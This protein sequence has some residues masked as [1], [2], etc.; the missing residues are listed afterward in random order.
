MHILRV[1]LDEALSSPF[2]GIVLTLVCY[3]IGKWVGGRYRSV[4]ANPFLIALVSIIVFLQVT[5]IPLES[6]TN[7]ADVFGLMLV[8]ATAF[9]GTTIYR[10]RLF[11][12]ANFFPIVLGCFTGACTSIASVYFLCRLFGVGEPLSTSLMP[13]SVTTPIAL[14]L[15]RLS[16]GIVP[17]TVATVALTGIAGVVCGP[18]LTRIF[19]IDDPIVAG[20]SYGT[21]SHV[22]G[23]TKALEL[24][25]VEGAASGISLCVTGLFTVFIFLAFLL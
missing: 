4:W 7:G 13:K 11:M 5:G 20:V 22:V 25:E 9:L 18:I 21:A 14:E 6:Y 17:L 8:P 19:H 2:F 15:A 10:Q 1:A 24:G 23:T 3:R 16:G 12:K